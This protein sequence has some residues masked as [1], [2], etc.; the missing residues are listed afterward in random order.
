MVDDECIVDYGTTH[1]VLQ[2]QIYFIFLSM[3]K[4]FIIAI[5]GSSDLIE[6]SGRATLVLPN[7]TPLQ[8]K[9]AL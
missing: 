8:I 5:V 7:V 9:N 3:K 6:G 4:A 2:K 1:I